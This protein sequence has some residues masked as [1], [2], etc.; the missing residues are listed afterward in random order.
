MAA[1]VL[2]LGI[3][4]LL[5]IPAPCP[6]LDSRA[7]S[8]SAPSGRAW[9]RLAGGL[10]A[11]PASSA[12]AHSS[13]HSVSCGPLHLHPWALMPCRKMSSNA[14]PWQ[15]QTGVPTERAASAGWLLRLPR[16][17]MWLGR[18]PTGSKTTGRWA[19]VSPQPSANVRVIQWRSSLPDAN[20]SQKTHQDN[21]RF[22][23]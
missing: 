4:L 2:F 5:P 12:Q 11:S 16:Q 21:Y 19:D 8:A 15:S 22:T 18:Q 9:P 6:L 7:W 13:G 23:A 1:R 20:F 3:L 14:C 17:R 10:D